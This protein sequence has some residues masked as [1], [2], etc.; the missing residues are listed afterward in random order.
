[1]QKMPGVRGKICIRN[2]KRCVCGA[3]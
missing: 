1:M 3:S 2:M